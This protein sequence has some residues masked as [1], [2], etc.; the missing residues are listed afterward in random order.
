MHAKPIQKLVILGGGTAGWLSAAYLQRAFPEKLEITLIESDMVP[1]IGVGEATVPTLRSTLH[2][3]GLEDKDWIPQTG[4]GFKNGIKFMNWNRSEEEQR[5]EN[6]PDIFYHPFHHQRNNVVDLYGLSYFMDI[7]ARLPLGHYW[8]EEKL[9][10][11][12]KRPFAYAC[13][14]NS[15]LCDENKA[16]RSLEAASKSLNYAY[17][18]DAQLFANMLKK[19]ATGRGVK[20]IEGKFASAARNEKGFLTSLKLED[21]Q[22]IEGDLFIDCTGF[23]SVLLTNT[24]QEYFTSQNNYL[25]CDS[26]VALQP[27]YDDREKQFEPYTSSI[28]LSAGWRWNI[29]LQH[30]VGSGYVFSSKFIDRPDAEKE[31]RK[32]IGEHRLEGVKPNH[33]DMRVGFHE[34]VWSHNCIGIG[35][36]GSFIEPLESTSIFMTEFQLFQLVRHFPAADCSPALRNQY[37][38]VFRECYAEIRDFVVMHYALSRRTDTPFW[39]EAKKDHRIPDSLKAKLALFKE[40]LPLDSDV[41]HH[42]FHAFNYTCLLDGLGHLPDHVNPAQYYHPADAGKK[43]LDN[44]ALQT[45]QLRESLPPIIDFCE[46]LARQ[47]GMEPM[48]PHGL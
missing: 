39:I 37:N 42:L 19:L 1:R 45:Q 48:K 18:F 32:S 7:D 44:I 47:V 26:A 3:L 9:A 14:P 20:R 36:A 46:G 16:P 6:K 30:R 25:L 10:G 21:G 12:E 34:N 35:L 8:L 17:H 43:L 29:P 40:R 22:K 4:A 31:L 28:A 38:K 15:Q 5:K 13:S 23:R 2:F 33:I 11:R 24:L 41:K 27:V